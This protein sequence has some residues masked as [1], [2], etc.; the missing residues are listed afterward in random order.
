[1]PFTKTRRT[2][3]K[4]VSIN[5]KEHAKKAQ[6]YLQQAKNI[7][8][9]PSCAYPGASTLL[10]EQEIKLNI[11]AA[12]HFRIAGAKHWID[13]AHAYAQA[14]ALATG[15]LMDSEKSAEL[16][17]EAAIVMEKVDTDL[18]ND[19]YRKLTFESSMPFIQSRSGLNFLNR[20]ESPFLSTVTHR[21]TKRRHHSKS[22][23]LPFTR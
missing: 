21:S 14:A 1:M 13:S 15:A 7:C 23:W 20:K 10:T 3:L 19:H 9:T 6:S 8:A 17:S 18:A 11:L 16:Y 5:P 12:E 4:A 22:A 2:E